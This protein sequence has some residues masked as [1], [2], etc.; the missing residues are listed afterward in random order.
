MTT[1]MVVGGQWGDEGKG[2]CVDLLAEHAQHVMRSQGGANA[3]H[4]IVVDKTEYKLHLIPSGILNPLPQCYLGAGMVIDPAKLLEE[5]TMLENLGIQVK[6]RLWISSRS[7]VVMPYH[8]VIDSLSGAKIGTTGKGIGPCYA[9]KALRIGIRMNDLVN[10][11]AFGELLAHVLELKNRELEKI[12]N[13]SPLTFEAILQE[14]SAYGHQLSRY[15]ADVESIILDAQ[16]KQENILLEGAQ[17]AL[18]DNT[19][20]TYPFV[21]SSSTSAAG[22]CLSAGLAPQHIHKTVAILKA[23]CTRVGQGPFPTE[24]S[25]VASQDHN[26][27]REVG[28]T[29]G[30]KR[31]LGWFDAVLARWTTQQS[32]ATSLAITKLDV[33]DGLETVKICTGY[34]LNGKLLQT[35]P[36]SAQ[37]LLHAEP[38]YEELPGWKTPT[39]QLTHY[40]QLP[41]EAKCYLKRLEQL[42][43]TP[44]S[45]VSVGPERSQTFILSCP[46][47]H[48][49]SL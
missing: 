6:G 49:E 40:D 16:S 33:L 32:G 44:I 48:K 9:D 21:T 46:Y 23:Y 42:C 11:E 15:V 17:G 39:T 31:R 24:D 25:T 27:I 37:D 2:K 22:I 5:I 28:T 12:H 43:Q 19:F 10:S 4:T 18:L 29:T 45:M 26:T 30:R 41:N 38:C 36:S 3:G 7:H 1:V 20:G 34:R 35:V 8:K 47:V 13:A 14:Y